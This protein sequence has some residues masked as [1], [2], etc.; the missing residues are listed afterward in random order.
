MLDQRTHLK[1]SKKLVGEVIEIKEGFSKVKL[2]ANAEMAVDDKGL[3]HGGFTF[4]LADYAAMVCVNHPNVVLGSADV[5]FLAPV[6]TGEILEAK[7]FHIETQGK[8]HIIEVEI[9]SE[10]KKVFSGKF[11]CY[12][13]DKHV[14]D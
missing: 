8:K 12:V 2:V 6:K 14:L 1:T 3:I 10:Q 4:G 9:F 13:L 11:S 7:A 5:K